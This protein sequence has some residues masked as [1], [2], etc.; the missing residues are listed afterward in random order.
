MSKTLHGHLP[1]ITCLFPFIYHHCG[2]YMLANDPPLRSACLYFI[3]PCSNCLLHLTSLPPVPN[4]LSAVSLPLLLLLYKSYTI[5]Q[6]TC[7]WPVL[8]PPS[9]H[10]SIIVGNHELI[11]VFECSR[12]MHP[13]CERHSSWCYYNRATLKA[14]LSGMAS[15]YIGLPWLTLRLLNSGQLS[16]QA[17]CICNI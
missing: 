5:L 3:M 1:F 7:T 16:P 10:F 11:S 9:G 13:V 6:F 14:V 12:R 8:V 4:K 2:S 15:L 17:S